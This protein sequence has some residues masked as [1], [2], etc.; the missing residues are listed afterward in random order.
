MLDL[1]LLRVLVALRQAG[2]V[3][4]A[5]ERL[6]LSQPAT[7]LALKRLRM[8]LGDPLFVRTGAGMQPTSHCLAIL[9]GAERAL[10]A[11]RTEILGQPRFDPATTRRRYTLAMNDVGEMALLPA[12]MAH[13]A[14][15]APLCDVHTE[16]LSATAIADGL[17]S[18]RVD[19]ALGY[20]PEVERSGFFRQRLFTRSFACL[21]RADHPRVRSDRISMRTFLDL[22]HVLVKPQGRSHDL[23]ETYLKRR[24]LERR[25]QLLVPHFMSV[26]SIVA[27]TDLI[28]TI[29]DSLADY[30]SRLEDV[31]VVRPPVSVGGFAVNQYWHTRFNR[32][33]AISWLRKAVR[34]LFQGD[35]VA[36]AR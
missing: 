32:D 5:A 2:S 24:G 35:R 7:S 23:F 22:G 13:F 36:D 19:L 10:E 20:Y 17:E 21:V 8:A 31:R 27:G 26:P 14:K 16:T 33:P 28:V 11:V 18:G 9:P 25:V 29:P 12:L 1:N 4:A 30:F 3:S 34:E 6:G 15:H